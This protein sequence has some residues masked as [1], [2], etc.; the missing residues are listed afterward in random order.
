MVKISQRFWTFILV[1]H[2]CL[3]VSSPKICFI[4]GAWIGGNDIETEGNWLWGYPDGEVMTYYNW[5]WQQPN[6]NIWY[7][8]G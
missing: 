6:N 5:G 1:F 8:E 4:I 7:G 2:C 3:L